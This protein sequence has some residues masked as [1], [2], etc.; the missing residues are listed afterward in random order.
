MPEVAV[1][2]HVDAR[3]G[4][5]GLFGGSR[6]AHSRLLPVPADDDDDDEDAAPPAVVAAVLW[7]WSACRRPGRRRRVVTATRGGDQRQ[8]QDERPSR[9][10]GLEL[11]MA[12]SSIDRGRGVTRRPTNPDDGGTGPTV[13]HHPMR[14]I[15]PRRCAPHAERHVEWHTGFR[16]VFGPSRTG[17]YRRGVPTQAPGRSPAPPMRA[18]HHLGRPLFELAESKLHAPVARAGIVAPDRPRRRDGGGTRPPGRLRRRSGRLRQDDA[19]GPVGGARQQP[20]VG[21]LTLDGPRQRPSRAADL[22][23]RGHRPHR[24]H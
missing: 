7:S 12:R 22:C 24:G 3:Q 5:D 21:W 2:D 17:Q 4:L 19:L 10:A 6:S 9:A 15:R 20:R 23:R 18:D 13:G 8:R 14:M 16:D 11:V 1:L